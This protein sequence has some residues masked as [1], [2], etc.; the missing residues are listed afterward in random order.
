MDSPNERK[1]IV[2][3]QASWTLSCGGVS[4]AVT[5][6]GGHLGPASFRV[7]SRRVQPLSVAPWW[8]ERV[9]APPILQVLRGDFFCLPFGGNATPYRGERHDVHGETANRPWEFVRTV[10]GRDAALLQLRLRTRARKGTVDKIVEI[11]RG[12]SAIYQRHLLSGFSGRLNP[13]HHAMLRFPAEGLVSTSPIRFGQV[14]PRP[15]ERPPRGG[16]SSLKPGARFRSLEAVRAADGS[17]ADLSR[18]PA[19]EGFEDLVLIASRP[20]AFAWTA[21]VFPSERWLWIAFK[22]PATLAS[23]VLWHSNGGRHYPPW[24]GRHRAVL[25]LEEVTAH[26]HDGLAESAAANPL[27]RLGIPTCLTLSPRRTTAINYIMAVL[28]IPAGFDHVAAVERGPDQ[29]VVLVSRSGRT[30][31]TTLDLDFLHER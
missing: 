2:H 7:A 15:F 4:L 18:Y 28:P 11:R 29:R 9:A 13:G 30:V 24:N 25:G 17:L 26:F 6:R 31:Q 16:Y 8:N 20:G 10:R 12:H 3:G 23:T 5:E 21:V 14:Y 22:D 1:R 19:R 27:N